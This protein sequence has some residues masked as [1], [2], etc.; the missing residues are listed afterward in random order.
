MELI[1]ISTYCQDILEARVR[2]VLYDQ[3][4]ITR[5][6][7]MDKVIRGKNQK[8]D[9]LTF[10]LFSFHQVYIIETDKVEPR[11]KTIVVSFVNQADKWEILCLAR[12]SNKMFRIWKLFIN[13]SRVTKMTNVTITE[14]LT[15]LR[16]RWRHK[17]GC[18]S[19]QIVWMR[20]KTNNCQ[21][22]PFYGKEIQCNSM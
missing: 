3:L 5:D 1:K 7:P 21:S 20:D 2:S 17:I 13:I 9:T 8:S 14:D 6:I 12:Y 4:N 11:S 15:N 10:T 19:N 16:L 22:L 18:G